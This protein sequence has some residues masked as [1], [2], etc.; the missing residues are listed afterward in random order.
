MRF[1]CCWCQS[2]LIRRD[3]HRREMQ[4]TSWIAGVSHDIR[5]PLAL[6]IGYA[7]ELAHMAERDM[8]ISCAGAA[9]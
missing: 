6:V 2:Y 9:D 4:R 5:T 8:E 7:D 1:C 3:A